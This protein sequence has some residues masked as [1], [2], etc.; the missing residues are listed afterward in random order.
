MTGTGDL[1]A[2]VTEAQRLLDGGDPAQAQRLFEVTWRTA[3][4]DELE[5]WEG[6]G[7][8]AAGLGAAVGDGPGAARELRRGAEL[9]GVFEDHPP[10]AL[11]VAGLRAW[12]RHLADELDSGTPVETVPL[13]R[14]RMP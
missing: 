14:L 2:V 8:L 10:H 12:A 5:L 6:L 11:D 9:V 1:G 7:R 13:P 3:P 4:A